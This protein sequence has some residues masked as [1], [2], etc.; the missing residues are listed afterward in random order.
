MSDDPIF[1]RLWRPRR[2][3]RLEYNSTSDDLLSKL[4]AAS[5][6]EEREWLVMQFSL[7]NLASEVSEGV[8]A[9][10][11]PHW[12][13]ANFLAVLLDKSDAETLPIFKQL[14]ALSFIEPFQE[15]G[16][17]IHE[18]SRSLL[19]QQLWHDD[20]PRYLKF[21]QRAADYCSNQDQSD[22]G[23]RIEY[24]YHLLIAHP[25]QGAT[26][27]ASTGWD[28]HNS[29]NFAYSKV[30]A[31]AQVVRELADADRLSARGLAWTHFW[32]GLLDYDYS[33]YQTAKSK[34]L[35]IK[36]TPAED[37][38]LAA[39]VSQWL[40]NILA[41]LREHDLAQPQ[42]EAALYLFK[43]IGD[44][45]GQANC[46]HGLGDI[47]RDLSEHDQ[48]RQQY[49][50]ALHLYQQIGNRLGEANSIQGLGDI[51]RVFNQYDQARQQYEAALH[52]YQQI[53]DRLGQA[54]SIQRLGDIHRV[55][56][57]Y[58][59]A[60]Q[61]YE[62]ALH[63]FKQIGNRLGEANCIQMLGDIHRVLNEYDQARRQNEAA[64][65]LF[66][67][68]GDRLGEA[69]CIHG[70]GDIHLD[71][72]EHNQARRQYEA[73][74]HLFKQ[75]GNRLGEANSIQMLGDIQ[76]VFNEYDQARQQ[77]E[78]AMLLFQQIGVK[79]G[80]AN[81]YTGLIACY[82]KLGMVNEYLQHV[83]LVRELMTK[84]TVYNR[85]CF[86][87]VCG[88]IDEAL[89]LLRP[90]LENREASIGWARMDPDFDWIRD[91]PRFELLL[92]E[93]ASQLGHRGLPPQLPARMLEEKMLKFGH[94]LTGPLFNE[95]M[96]IETVSQEN[97]NI[98]RLGL[99]GTQSE[100]FRRVTLN[101][102]DIR[103]LDIHEASANYSGDPTILRLGLQAYALGIAYEF[104]P[105][106]GLSISRVDPLPHQLEAVYDHLLKLPQVRFLLAD[107]AGAGKTV[108]AG[109]LIRELKLRGLAE[110]IL[111]VCPANLTFQWQREL[112]EKFDE[113]F[114]VFTGDSIRDQFGVNQWLANNRII[115]S[116]DLAKRSQL[117]PGLSQA[118]WDLVIVDEAHR[119]SWSPPARKTARYALGELLRD[120][121]DHMLMLTA[122]P[123]KGDPENFNLFLQL[124]DPDAFADVRSIHQAMGRGRA[125]FYLRRT[126]EAMVN[127]PDLQPDGSWIAR[128][129]FTKRITHTIDFTIDGDEFNLYRSVTNFVKRQ[130]ARAAAQGDDPR[131]R[132]VGFLMSLYQRRLASSTYAVRKSLE[133]RARRLDEGVK[134]AQ[135]LARLAPPDL[136]DPEELEEIEEGERERLE[137]I[138]EAVTLAGNAAQVR[139]EIAELKFL[140]EEARSVEDSIA[141]A[142]L[143]RLRKLLYEQGFFDDEHQRL[144]IFTEYKDTLDYLL[145]RLSGWGFRVGCIHGGMKIGSR[146]ESGTR[147]YAEQQFKDGAIQIL[148]ATE[149]A[150]EGI[151]LQFCHI[152]FNYDIP[153]NPNRLEQRMGRIHRYG[154]QK[155]CLIFNFVAT[156]TIEGQVLQR[157]LDKLQEI[158]DA[159]DDDA[160]FNVVGEIL[161]A[162]QIERVLRDYYAGK[163][164]EADLEDRLLRNIDE[165]HF[166]AICRNA[167]EG[168]AS[169]NLNL[170]M[171]IERRARAQERRVVPE[172]IARF[173]L[174]SSALV[175]WTLKPL[176]SIPNTFDP[177]RTPALLRQYE[178]QPNWNLPPLAD[179]YPRCSI[180]RKSA[181]NNKL[182]WVTPGHPLFEALR[183]HTLTLAHE[184]LGPGACFYSLQHAAPARLDF[185]RARVVDGL[186]HTIHERL[187][188]GEI[189]ENETG[190]PRLVDPN[191][192]GDFTPAPTPAELPP[193][194]LSPEVIGWLRD[195][196]LM[197]FLEEVRAERL[198]EV[199]R[200]ADHVELSL[201][202]LIHKADEEIGRAAEDVERKIQGAE[203]RQAQA[204][205][206]HA[207]LVARRNRRR[208][209]LERQRALSLQAVDRITTVLVLPH[210]QREAPE[211]RN[212]RQNPETEAVALRFVIDHERGEGRQVFDVS[213]KNLGYDITSL[214]LNSGDLRLIEVKG[215][216][217]QSGSVLLTPNERRVAE[218]RRDCYW[219]Y[220][221]TD[222]NAE[223]KL[224][225]IKDPAR[226]DWH[227][228]TKVAHYWLDFK[229]I[230]K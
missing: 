163:L 132:A 124:L 68:I 148:V 126:K 180:D 28:W 61:Q 103:Q 98:W 59:Q 106:F 171:L 170:Q 83:T 130:S 165:G 19:L 27:F 168:L 121:S 156:N 31:L 193:I 137:R 39:N 225:P 206:R 53:G 84:E 34:L 200:V 1:G 219:L 184:A 214:D 2:R 33:R 208:L 100:R 159:L 88:D 40:G 72:S 187:F 54:N 26:E 36:I 205:E 47:H 44:R 197:P 82:S 43:Q 110:R 111:I 16:Y 11:I 167:L 23:W 229:T 79:R 29:P 65:H 161:P 194:A 114:H 212:L 74:L 207:N 56:N 57:E 118:N 92:N 125:P 160:V 164:G 217:A 95:P 105:Y 99:V 199:N 52:L 13:D 140:I 22:M 131:A 138:L 102:D 143:T 191:L 75:I 5:S 147:L 183:R 104:D 64:L 172:T 32:E 69:N 77:Y 87:S 128:K 189:S 18:R 221:V 198:T 60:R 112:K 192:L 7:D 196:A 117:L 62:A 48:A 133:N 50:A 186:G 162:A 12:F 51:H 181:E 8:W 113:Q 58:D 76:R 94:I 176:P 202:E 158:R 42:Y 38:R 223:P 134:E 89:N 177:A 150:G 135:K 210:P 215:I 228:V 97:Q 209:E 78:A 173:V 141:E 151:N 230:K 154:Q 46:I 174:E 81:C 30:E 216:G 24:I 204:E 149:A 63:L 179:R 144:L 145:T 218:D 146:N 190:L 35:Q 115:T 41:H 93:M 201:S 152:L 220:V 49:E 227:E 122:T 86:A 85:A 107:D 157:L 203:G 73:A 153:W 226:L 6:H 213:E 55:T 178:A 25:E 14:L 185:Y 80:E 120:R 139:E 96:R 129:I 123:H 175:P 91:D 37:I 10:A 71:L 224:E 182:E 109:L 20:Q 136:P 15:R 67:Q 9:A 70:L 127:F 195:N 3:R 155:N 90:A 4:M 66:K 166:R 21:A 17:N 119:M 101:S 116:L 169:K 211:V 188:V 142:K 108:M 45:L 222:C